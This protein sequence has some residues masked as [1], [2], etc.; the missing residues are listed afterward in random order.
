LLQK[1]NKILNSGADTEEVFKTIVDGLRSVYNYDSVAIH[2]LS[3]DKMHLTVKSY[4]AESMSKRKLEKL[5]GFK[6]KGY[7]VPLYEG[8]LLKKVVDTKKAVIS[9]DIIWVLKSYTDR[10]SLQRLAKTAA[11][12]TKAKWGMGAPLM[13]GNKLVGV[14]GCG[15]IKKLT[16][17][18]AQRFVNFGAQAGQSIERAQTYAKLESAYKEVKHSNK[19]K[20]LF[21]D[22][23]RHD[24][25]NPAGVTKG[26]A[27]LALS[28]E[29][30]PDKKEALTMIINNTNKVID[31]IENASILAKIESGE[32]LKLKKM[33]LG[34]VLKK[35]AGEISHLADKKRTKIKLDA[36]GEFKVM[37]NPLMIEVFSNLIDNAVKYSPNDS[38][39]VINI[40]KDGPNW[41]ISVSDEGPG[42]TD[43]YKE[44]V[45]ERFKRIK[46]SGVKGT[47]LGLA[48]VKKIVE[49]HNGQTWVEDKQGGGS[50]FIVEIPKAR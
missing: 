20:D 25:L 24:L 3:Q 2:L 39:V 35:S 31:L 13:A 32:D 36:K 27:E 21:I 49:L 17:A 29:D 33:D 38:E 42:I 26:I 14:I 45:F 11:K 12:L 22:I 9:D 23:M 19:L 6:V 41:K 28:E 48:I 1:I 43:E 16:K 37:A 7:N 47:G 4:S 10:K 50:I 46:K 30:E 8:S 40:K 15:S 18:D 5:I 44:A 34:N